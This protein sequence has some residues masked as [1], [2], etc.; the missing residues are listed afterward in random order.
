MADTV[1]AIG[2]VFLFKSV[3]PTVVLT[4]LGVRESLALWLLGGLGLWVPGVLAATTALFI[5]NL[6]LPGLGGVA[7]L[8]GKPR[9]TA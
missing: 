9:P 3:V 7:V 6:L 8:W 5:L 2:L 4:E 1:A